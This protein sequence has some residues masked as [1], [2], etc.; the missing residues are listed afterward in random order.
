MNRTLAM[1]KAAVAVCLV[2]S[3]ALV[4]CAGA[5]EGVS[6]QAKGVGGFSLGVGSGDVRSN[7]ATLWSRADSA[8]AVTVELRRDQTFTSCQAGS[9]NGSTVKTVQADP[10]HDLTVQSRFDQLEPGARYWYRFCSGPKASAV[11]SFATSP[12][13][14]TSADIR[15]AFTGDSDGSLQGKQTKFRYPFDVYRQMA[16]ENNNFNINGGDV[17]YSD[18]LSGEPW[19]KTLDQKYGKFREI[20]AQADLRDF[21]A[22]TSTYSHWDDHE[23]INGFTRITGGEEQYWNGVTAFRDYNPVNFTEGDGIFNTYSWGSNLDLFILDETSFRSPAADDAPDPK[24]CRNSDGQ[25]ERLPMVPQWRRTQLAEVLKVPRLKSATPASCLAALDAPNRTI[26]GKKQIEQFKQAVA[27]STARFK[28]VVSTSSLQQLSA[29]PYGRFE[30]YPRERKEIVDFLA[31]QKNVVVLTTDIHGT[32]IGQITGSPF[33]RNSHASSGITEVA[34]GPAA[35]EKRSV[36]WD[37]YFREIP[38]ASATLAKQLL[39]APPP[40]GIGLSCANLSTF[41]YAQVAVTS[42]S[43]T[44]TAK[45]G[46]GSTVMSLDGNPC[47]VLVSYRN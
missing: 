12:Q 36:A 30:G 21:R 24:A 40:N 1:R 42:D 34:T 37:G 14:D 41:S 44:V 28:V 16:N 45:D 47:T 19:A 6:R 27:G 7:A 43:L 38:N 11:G 5:D 23:W 29:G 17:M 9:S 22:N 25:T 15:F 10:S 35:A 18:S 32:L 8:G 31:T 33:N 13:P 46:S 3:L 2:A 20:L 26:L 39:L 4:S